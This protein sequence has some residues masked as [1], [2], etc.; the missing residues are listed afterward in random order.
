MKILI[1]HLS[2]IHLKSQ[3]NAASERLKM[4]PQAVRNV[5]IDVSAVVVVASGDI[6]YSGDSKEYDIAMEDWNA[7]L[8]AMKTEFPGAAIHFIAVPGNHDCSLG[9]NQ[10]VRDIVIGKVREENRA[11]DEQV[12]STCTEVQKGF[13]N[14]LKAMQSPQPMGNGTHAYYNYEIAVLGNSLLIRCYNNRYKRSLSSHKLRIAG[15]H[16]C[17]MTAMNSREHKEVLRADVREFGI[18]SARIIR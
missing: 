14:F 10:S 15:L 11:F 2:D 12:I 7:L 3:K 16:D 6:A 13:R 5:E 17:C 4:V 18:A 8:A 9:G 1:L